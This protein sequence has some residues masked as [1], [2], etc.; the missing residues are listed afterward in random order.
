[1]VHAPSRLGPRHEL[2]RSMVMATVKSW[3]MLR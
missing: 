3:R 1:M 2:D